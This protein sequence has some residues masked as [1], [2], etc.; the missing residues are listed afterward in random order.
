MC[1]VKQEKM[2]YNRRDTWHVYCV[3]LLTCRIG[4][5]VCAH[6]HNP[7]NHCCS[8]S[9]CSYFVNHMSQSLSSR[10]SVSGSDE[11]FVCHSY[12]IASNVYSKTPPQNKQ[13]LPWE[14]EA[15]LPSYNDRRKW[16]LSV[17]ASRF[18]YERSPW[19]SQFMKSIGVHAMVWEGPFLLSE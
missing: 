11:A 15:I 4:L 1:S 8:Q 17:V 9:D 2:T 5:C 19:K 14:S 18:C 16:T 12:N 10:G 13:K 6:T 7:R 3:Q